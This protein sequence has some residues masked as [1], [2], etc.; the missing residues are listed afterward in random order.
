MALA[1]NT[2]AAESARVKDVPVLA[3]VLLAATHSDVAVWRRS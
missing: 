2:P 1:G 3:R